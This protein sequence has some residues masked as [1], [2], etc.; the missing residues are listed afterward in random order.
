MGVTPSFRRPT[1]GDKMRLNATRPIDLW[2]D[3][4][5]NIQEFELE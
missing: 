2:A 5:I 3:D 1:P 4:L